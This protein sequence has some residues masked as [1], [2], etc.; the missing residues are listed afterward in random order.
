[1]GNL[2]TTLVVVRCEVAESLSVGTFNSTLPRRQT[3]TDL[4]PSQWC[5][6]SRCGHQHKRNCDGG[7]PLANI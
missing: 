5:R 7:W 4:S 2:F 1:M 3:Q 6:G